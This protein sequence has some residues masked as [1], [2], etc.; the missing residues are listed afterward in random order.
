[1][2]VR[3]FC[4]VCSCRERRGVVERVWGGGGVDMSYCLVSR[5]GR[6]FFSVV[7]GFVCV[8]VV[9]FMS[10]VVC[11]GVWEGGWSEGRGFFYVV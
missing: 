2:R 10:W 5:G 6:G 1:M 11:I 3:F 4:F 7:L 9:F 8:C